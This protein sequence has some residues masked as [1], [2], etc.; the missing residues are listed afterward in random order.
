MFTNSKNVCA[1]QKTFICSRNVCW[2]KKCSW[3]QNK[4][5]CIK[6]VKILKNNSIFWIQKKNV[7]EMS[8]F[9]HKIQIFFCK[10]KTIFMNLKNVSEKHFLWISKII[11]EFQK[12][13][14]YAK[15]MFMSSKK[16][17]Q[18]QKNVCELKNVNN[19]KICSEISKKY[20]WISETLRYTNFFKIIFS[21]SYTD[22]WDLH[23]YYALTWV[24]LICVIICK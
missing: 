8:K 1:F 12:M 11:H 21:V 13:S 20:S 2:F 15:H 22:M 17:T 4:C 5:Q 24:A 19:L 9:V 6:N 10:F 18:F 14:A 16:C 23:L 3:F 7:R